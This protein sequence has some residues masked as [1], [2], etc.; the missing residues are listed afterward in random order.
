MD[1]RLRV[2]ILRG[3]SSMAMNV[4]SSSE[5][6]TSYLD[7][8]EDLLEYSPTLVLAE[9]V[10]GSREVLLAVS[11]NRLIA[12]SQPIVQ[13]CITQLHLNEE[14][15]FCVDIVRLDHWMKGLI[16]RV[17]WN[18]FSVRRVFVRCGFNAGF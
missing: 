14:H 16:S 6:W 5:E 2:E 15:D 7:C 18:E 17:Q 13:G 1:E 10:E 8:C 3:T 4:R 11:E 9:I 12:I